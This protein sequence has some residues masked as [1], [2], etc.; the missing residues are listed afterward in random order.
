MFFF[1]SLALTTLVHVF[2]QIRIADVYFHLALRFF[3]VY[4]CQLF[5]VFFLCPAFF[6]VSIPFLSLFLYLLRQ[7]HENLIKEGNSPR[8]IYAWFTSNK[9]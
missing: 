8:E 3:M 5:V 2:H 9:R 1:F 6:L 4:F 7:I